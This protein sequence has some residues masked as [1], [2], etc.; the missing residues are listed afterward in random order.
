MNGDERIDYIDNP[1][2]EY[3][4]RI[5]FK[6]AYYPWSLRRLQ[7]RVRSVVETLQCEEIRRKAE[8]DLGLTTNHRLVDVQDSRG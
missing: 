1:E 8:K 7:E 4:E 6:F 5:E 2:D 3:T